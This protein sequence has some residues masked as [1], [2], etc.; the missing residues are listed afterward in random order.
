MTADVAVFGNIIRSST[1]PPVMM[2]IILGPSTGPPN[3][4][5]KCFVGAEYV[6]RFLHRFHRALLLAACSVLAY[7]V[8]KPDAVARGSFLP[9]GVLGVLQPAVN[10]MYRTVLALLSDTPP[11]VLY[12]PVSAGGWGA[13]LLSVC[14]KLNFLHGYLEAF[15]GRN[16]LVRRV[17]HLQWGAPLP[18]LNDDADL[19]QRLCQELGL[20]WG[21][22]ADTLLEGMGGL[23][24]RDD[25]LATT[26][27]FVT[28]DAGHEPSSRM[29]MR[30]E[31]GGGGGGLGLVFVTVCDWRHAF[32][33]GIPV[34]LG[35]NTHLEWLANLLALLLVRT[36]QGCVHMPCD[37]TPVQLCGVTGWVKCHSRMDRL[38]KYMVAL[39]V[40]HRVCEYWPPA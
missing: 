33:W 15:K 4:V 29:T 9:P 23:R 12:T 6:K 27:V 1:E 39:S 28:T 7:F 40:V 20:Q 5:A 17:L 34:V 3:L 30:R 25:I 32:S 8:S 10:G 35:C 18:L 37:N 31:P 21:V 22:G 38:A 26:E 16:A 14:G 2:G 11:G 13:L 19:V 24:L 36:Y